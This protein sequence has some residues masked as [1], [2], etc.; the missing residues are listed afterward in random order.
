VTGA[1]FDVER[2]RAALRAASEGSRPR[3]DCP[4]PERLWGTLQKELP[5]EARREVIEHLAL[6]PACSEAWRMAIEML[7]GPVP[8][9]SPARPWLPD[10]L[11]ARPFVPLAAAAALVVAVGAGLLLDRAPDVRD[12][13]GYREGRSPQIL[14]R[15]TEDEPLPR[16][17]FR[18]RWSPGPQGTRYDVRVTTESLEPVASVTGR[19]E[20]EWLVPESAL[21]PLPSGA[22][23]LWQVEM[24]LPGGE[25]RDSETFA[26]SLR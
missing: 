8:E 5:A 18:L 9:A 23:L 16:D 26:A 14:S 24:R 15:V 17:D 22:R 11:G 12:E 10:W 19:T 4:P 6:C 13:P 7:P 1:D 21:A 25:R 3:D 2:L 20:P